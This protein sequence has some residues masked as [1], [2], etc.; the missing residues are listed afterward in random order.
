MQ[1]QVVLIMVGLLLTACGSNDTTY[2]VEE[3]NGSKATITTSD[4]DEVALIQTETA[5]VVVRQGGKAA[6]FSSY[7]PQYPGSTV[8][9]SMDYQTNQDGA[10]GNVTMQTSDDVA[11]V[12][13]FYKQSAISAGLKVVMEANTGAGSMLAA[14]S[15]GDDNPDIMISAG[16][17][18]DGTTTVTL[19]SSNQ[20]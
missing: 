17:S 3:G 15:K 20:K 14:S 4:D 2:K 5:S 7:A 18:D 16:R 9:S 19:T 6:S 12:M 8:V 13:A 11:K 10:G 1:V